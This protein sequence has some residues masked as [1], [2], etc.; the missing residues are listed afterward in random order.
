MGIPSF[1]QATHSALVPVEVGSIVVVYGIL[2]SFASFIMCFVKRLFVPEETDIMGP[3]SSFDV[4]SGVPGCFAKFTS[5]MS[6]KS[7][8]MAVSYTHLYRCE[9]GGNYGFTNAALAGD[10]ADD[11]LDVRILVGSVMLRLTGGA[12]C[13]AG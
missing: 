2:L 8:F 5:Q 6:A 13:R 4:P 7:G 11:V 3:L 10:N 9:H 1:T 12:V